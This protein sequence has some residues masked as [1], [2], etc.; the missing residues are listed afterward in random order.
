MI[1]KVRSSLQLFLFNSDLKLHA[2]T[3]KLATPESHFNSILQLIAK[4]S[5]KKA[6]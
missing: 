1:K 5:G 2:V 4:L 6:L 3:A